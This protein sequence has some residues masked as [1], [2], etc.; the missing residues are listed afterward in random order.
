MWIRSNRAMWLKLERGQFPNLDFNWFK[1]NGAQDPK[2]AYDIYRTW[3]ERQNLNTQDENDHEAFLKRV[4]LAATGLCRASVQHYIKGE[5][6][7][8]NILAQRS[9]NIRTIRNLDHITYMLVLG[10]Q[11]PKWTR[12]P[13][14]RGIP[15]IQI[16]I[17]TELEP[18]IVPS[19]SY[20]MRI[21]HGIVHSDSEHLFLTALHEVRKSELDSSIRKLLRVF[22]PNVFV[23]I[24]LTP[25]K[26]TLEFL[27]NEKVPV[28]LVH[29]DRHRKSY[30]TSPPV[31]CNIVPDHKKMEKDLKDWIKDH[32]CLKDL[33][34]KQVLVVSMPREKKT[35]AIRDERIRKIENALHSLRL[36]YDHIHVKGYSFDYAYNA[37]MRSHNSKLFICLSDQLAVGI[38]HLIMASGES[39]EHRIIG[40]DNSGLAQREKIPSFDQGIGRVGQ[41][42]SDKLGQFFSMQ[43]QKDD[44][45]GNF[46]E[47]KVAVRLVRA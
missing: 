34:K 27:R 46:E 17:L 12:K 33:R 15:G 23:L 10:G 19:F 47:K 16:A 40:F 38:K 26:D 22:N 5:D 4:L 37:Y 14:I 31:L 36:L 2:I 13:K 18:S 6:D 43:L 7:E 39:C 9:F 44:D 45:W 21:I 24:R 8:K 25:S 29:A 3:I 41:E 42:I 11:I 1:E 20:H 32:H 28:I 30:Y 35:G